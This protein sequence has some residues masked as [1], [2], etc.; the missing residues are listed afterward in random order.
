[1]ANYLTYSI[2]EYIKKSLVYKTIWLFLISTV[3]LTFSLIY[4]YKSE[5][6]NNMHQAKI[7]FEANQNVIM[8]K[9]DD[10]IKQLAHVNGFRLFLQ[11]SK[12]SRE[13]DKHKLL[14]NIEI[15][16]LHNPLIEGIEMFNN[17]NQ[18]VLHNG[19]KGNLS[20]IYNLVYTNDFID[21][22][23]EKFGY[24]KV[25]FDRSTLMSQL[26][27]NYYEVTSNIHAKDHL[28]NFNK[29]PNN[30]IHVDS[31]LGVTIKPRQQ[32]SIQWLYFFSTLLVLLAS[33]IAIA[34]RTFD[35]IIEPIKNIETSIFC[36]E[37]NYKLHTSD[38]RE[39]IWINKII[40]NIKISKLHMREKLINLYKKNNE[41][42]V[43]SLHYLKSSLTSSKLIMD[44]E[45]KEHPSYKDLS[46]NLVQTITKI[47]NTIN[48]FKSA[49]DKFDDRQVSLT[50]VSKVKEIIRME[51]EKYNSISSELFAQEIPSDVFIPISKSELIYATANIATNAIESGAQKLYVHI[52]FT[53]NALVIT[54]E[55]NGE[56]L[57]LAKA[58]CFLSGNTNKVNGTGTG[59]SSINN[60]LINNNS[61]M[62]F[63]PPSKDFSTKLTLK[64][65]GIY[66]DLDTIINHIRAKRILSEIIVYNQADSLLNPEVV[67]NLIISHIS[68]ELSLIEYI[69][70]SAK[71][72]IIDNQLYIHDCSFY[73]PL[74]ESN[75]SR[76]ILNEY[77]SVEQVV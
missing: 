33:Y 10:S 30:L 59:L 41:F 25:Y 13:R 64:I 35:K 42:T 52:C 61:Q 53:N 49:N 27:N 75:F 39:L 6:D 69:H 40:G 14:T 68:N 38:I 70:L 74:E 26:K 23:G 3:P 50:K 43:N 44:E 54:F 28:L 21:Q 29:F 18:Q 57:D 5:R 4:T 76:I 19:K 48:T 12:N 8:N 47:A 71:S 67:D 16:L 31:N 11:S 56:P 72:G 32:I 34:K 46:V 45:F 51:L 36:R 1:M 2:D 20:I 58:E 62:Y 37:V 63:S 17:D 15:L 73:M 7:A 22:Y 24:L 65:Q 66:N 55:N 60:L 9:L 77:K